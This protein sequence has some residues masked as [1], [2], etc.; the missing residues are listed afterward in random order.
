MTKISQLTD[1]GSGLASADEF[2]IRDVS[3]TGTPNKKLTANGFMNYVINQGSGVGFTQIAAGAGPLSRV[4]ALSSGSTGDVVI[5]TAPAGSLLERFRINSQGRIL[6][7]ATTTRKNNYGVG[8]ESIVQIE[9]TGGGTERTV[10]IVRNGGLANPL[11]GPLLNFTTSAGTTPGSNALVSNST[12]L[13]AVVFCGTDG[14]K[15]L[16]GALIVGIADGP[17]ASG[18]MPGRLEFRTTASGSLYPVE[19]MRLTSTGKLGIGTSAPARQLHTTES[20]LIG[21]NYIV[22]HYVG[23]FAD[24]TATAEYIIIGRNEPGDTFRMIGTVHGSRGS[25]GERN[26]YFNVCCSRTN[27]P[28]AQYDAGNRL[29]SANFSLVTLAYSGNSY[30]ALASSASVNSGGLQLAFTGDVY[31][32]YGNGLQWTHYDFYGAL[33]IPASAVSGVT[34]I[35]SF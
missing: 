14:V 32:S 26:V 18:V 12:E 4:R 20:V 3:D 8:E 17:T 15:P 21:G 10:D 29:G 6:A 19:R 24:P 22:N 11:S 27:L 13:G 16:Q 30:V 33:S 7:G 1:I 25:A 34:T 35:K 5:E 31:H 2:V 28:S 23:Y 9:F